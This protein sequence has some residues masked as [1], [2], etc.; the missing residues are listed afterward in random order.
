MP[1][2]SLPAR[3]TPEARALAEVPPELQWFQHIPNARTRA[4]YQ[5]DLQDFMAF[6]GIERPEDFRLVTRAHVIAWHDDVTRRA[7]SPA[8]VRR[9]PSA[10]SSWYQYLCAHNAVPLHGVMHFRLTGQGE[11]VRGSAGVV[12]ARQRVDDAGG[13]QAAEAAGGESHV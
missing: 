7:P 12:G 10:L 8:T 4:A 11:K 1:E 3:L 13:R 5:L 9:K 2:T 6:I